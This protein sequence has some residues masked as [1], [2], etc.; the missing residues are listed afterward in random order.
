MTGVNT[1]IDAKA[2]ARLPWLCRSVQADFCVKATQEEVLS[3]LV[4]GATVP[5]LAGLLLGYR[6]ATAEET[7]TDPTSE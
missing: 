6:K 1:K 4:L 3:A 5:Q 7:G 2:K